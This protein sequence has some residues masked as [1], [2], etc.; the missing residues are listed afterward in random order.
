[1]AISKNQIKYLRSLKQKKFRQMY[2]NFIAEGT[3]IA[4]ELLAQTA[5]PIEGIF[6]LENWLIE[7]EPLLT[8]C[9]SVVH[10]VSEKELG[11]ISNL[12]TPQQVLIVAKQPVLEFATPKLQQS[13]SLYLD[14]IQDPGNMGT[15]LRIADWFGIPN[16]L[17][18]DDCVEVYNPKVVQASMGAFLRVQTGVF[19]LK[20]LQ[21][22]ADF[23]L[24][25]AMMTGKNCFEIGTIQQG[26]LVI[27]NE[28]KGIRAATQEL[29]T[30]QITIPSNGGAESLN[31]AVATGILC[32]CLRNT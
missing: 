32:A 4:K 29:L 14:G 22:S 3:K 10:V 31:A 6:A 9:K 28:G 18:S 27:G 24:L 8:K 15:I 21:F 17:L 20:K 2:N 13:L 7:N 12:K 30:Q 5:F 11:Q 23:P 19:D 25:G 1:M 16:I 26:I